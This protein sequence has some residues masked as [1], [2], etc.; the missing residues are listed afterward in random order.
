MKK[1]LLYTFRTYP[2]IEELRNV[3]GEIFI[4]DKLKESFENFTE[5]VLENNIKLVIWVA[6][7]KWPSLMESISVN[8]FNRDK[9]ISKQWKDKYDLHIK[10]IWIN[11]NKW[12]TTSFCNRT[13]YKI[14]EFIDNNW[15]DSMLSF[16]HI[17]LQDID[18]LDKFII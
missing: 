12:F 14:S 5:I 15:L 16:V 2:Y 6:D 3:Y 4:F 10:D 17:N 13:M 8:K 11:I 9:L 1:I 7:R 18:K